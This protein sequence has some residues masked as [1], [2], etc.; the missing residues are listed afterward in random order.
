MSLAANSNPYQLFLV[1]YLTYKG[2]LFSASPDRTYIN[3]MR[4]LHFCPLFYRCNQ[5]QYLISSML[6][7]CAML[8]HSVMPNSL[9]PHGL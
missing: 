4:T 5:K 2:C 8:S 7:C 3:P 6:L 1:Y 9:Q